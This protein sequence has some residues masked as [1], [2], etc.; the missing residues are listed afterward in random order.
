MDADLGLDTDLGVD[1]DVETNVD[2]V[3]DDVRFGVEGVKDLIDVDL[4]VD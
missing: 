3:V 4:V 1:G 2:L